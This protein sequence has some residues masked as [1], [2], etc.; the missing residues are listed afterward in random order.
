MN[1]YKLYLALAPGFLLWVFFLPQKTNAPAAE[2]YEQSGVFQGEN[3]KVTLKSDAPLEIIE[4]SSHKLRG[5][6]DPEKQSFA[7]SLEIKSLEGFN[8]PLQREHFNENYLESTKYPKAS[9]S[10]KIIEKVDLATEGTYTVRAKGMLLLHGIEQERIIKSTIE[11]KNGKATVRATFT[12][13]LAD[14][15]ITI[16]RVVYQ[17]IAEEVTVTVYA[18]LKKGK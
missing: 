4:A 15:D 12:V 8:S 2:S 16:P 9:F 17:K 3:G 1:T 5:A 18:E 10:G 13:P 7:W 14:H 11:I 6:I